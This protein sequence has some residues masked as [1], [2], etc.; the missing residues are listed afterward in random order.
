MT[1]LCPLLS[2]VA[3]FH[4]KWSMSMENHKNAI[5]GRKQWSDFGIAPVSRSSPQLA[6]IILGK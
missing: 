2:Q 5:T 1:V 4:L 3:D 6:N